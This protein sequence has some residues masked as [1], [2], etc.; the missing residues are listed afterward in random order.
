VTNLEAHL[1]K[2]F[3]KIEGIIES[4]S[5]FDEEMAYWV[6]GKEIAHFR[7][8]NAIELRLTR[9][10]IR[11]RQVEL[12]ADQRVEPRSSSSD[13]I[14]VRFDSLADTE[15]VTGLA[16]LAAAAHRPPPGVPAK[17]PP[18]GAELERRRRFH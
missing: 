4:D 2:E 18:T 7:S 8:A 10:I 1:R 3:L 11:D 13:W 5:M 17:P 15:F 6:N 16:A 12:R 14:V 9:S